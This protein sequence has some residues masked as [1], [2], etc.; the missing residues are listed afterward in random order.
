MMDVVKR[1]AI[2]SAL[3]L[4]S[5]L[6]YIL[7]LV[8]WQM[9]YL[10]QVGR[11]IPFYLSILGFLLHLNISHRDDL[12][13]RRLF[14]HVNS[15]LFKIKKTLPEHAAQPEM[16]GPEPPLPTHEA[17]GEA[18][19]LTANNQ[20]R[21]IWHMD[22][23]SHQEFIASLSSE[24]N[25]AVDDMVK[26]KEMINMQKTASSG[27]GDAHRRSFYGAYDA[28]ARKSIEISKK[29]GIGDSERGCEA[30]RD[31]VELSPLQTG[32]GAP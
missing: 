12:P 29:R 9:G 7:F 17:L 3:H 26:A 23:S 24:E 4:S 22:S 32:A 11:G 21:N 27:L 19:Q 10:C 6:A 5:S 16:Y 2:G 20:R 30:H 28:N 18:K 25:A 1:T 13:L 31:T 14:G 15:L 8:M